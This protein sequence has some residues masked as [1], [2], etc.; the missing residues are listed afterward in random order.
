MKRSYIINY[1][2]PDIDLNTFVPTVADDFGFLL[3]LFIGEINS[4]GEECF[5]V[6]VC[7]PKWIELNY[8]KQT[9]LIGLHTIIVREFN[10]PKLMKAI[11]ELVC[12]DGVSWEAISDQIRY[13]GL[14]EL[15]HNHWNAYKNSVKCGA[16][17]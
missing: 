17:G 7:T 15:D 4:D 1:H 6:F 13:I 14:S 2:S 5:D 3:Q 11:E 10:F 8:D 16:L 9:V 12:I